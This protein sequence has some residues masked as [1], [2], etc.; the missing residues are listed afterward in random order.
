MGS[1]YQ[2]NILQYHFQRQY[3]A[4]KEWTSTFLLE[5]VGNVICFH[6]SK[7][8]LRFRVGEW[9]RSL[10][11]CSTFASWNDGQSL[12]YWPDGLRFNVWAGLSMCLLGLCLVSDH[13]VVLNNRGREV[14]PGSL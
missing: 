10:C 3:I 11:L 4:Y 14:V 8:N 7:I 5:L 2:I 12:L 1:M 6:F 13:T 9:V